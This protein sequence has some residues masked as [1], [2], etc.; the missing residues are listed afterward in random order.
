MPHSR[1]STVRSE[2]RCRAER[3]A[4]IARAPSAY[5]LCDH[6]KVGLHSFP[7]ARELLVCLLAPS[8]TAGGMMTSCPGCQFTGVATVCVSV[9]FLANRAAT[10]RRSR[11]EQAWCS[12]TLA[13]PPQSIATHFPAKRAFQQERRPRRNVNATG[14]ERRSGASRFG[15]DHWG[16]PRPK[17]RRNHG[18]SRRLTAAAGE[19]RQEGWSS[20][21]AS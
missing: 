9:Q 6:P 8:E 1:P 21:P 3:G 14:P 4:P 11:P 18:E 15:R 7:S 20:R 12:R 17:T 5:R 19:F 2:G 13:G 16:R 10:P